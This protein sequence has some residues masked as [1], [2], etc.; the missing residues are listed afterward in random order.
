[1]SSK[2]TTHP[3]V[4]EGNGKLRFGVQT[5][6]A[7]DWSV[8]RDFSQA[9]EALGFDSIWIA[10]HPLIGCDAW[11]TLAAIAG[12]TRRIRLGALVSCASY[13][14]PVVL[15]RQVAD[16]DRISNGRAILGLGSGDLAW[17]F[18]QQGLDWGTFADRHVALTDTLEIVPRLLG[19]EPVEYSGARFQV[20]GAVLSLPALQRPRVPIVIAGGG[21]KTTLRSVAEHADACNIGAATWAGGA[22]T[23]ELVREK[24][25]V[26]ERYCQEA[27]RPFESLL[28][29]AAVALYL[30]DSE[31]DVQARRRAIE[32]DPKRAWLLSFLGEAAL[33]GTPQQ[34]V[35]HLRNLARAGFQY[36]IV[37]ASPLDTEGLEVLASRIIPEIGQ[38]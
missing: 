32:T 14:N 2:H 15:A 24:F 37:I 26:L 27:G 20:R 36:I 34:A 7:A 17:E 11:T 30:G 29:T 3:W 4:T 10:D 8:T 28:R 13:K 16:V 18:H 6:L 1:M 33:F 19:G 31:A 38:S 5:S 23:P 21:V 25:D 9:A 22:F 12:T 35:Q